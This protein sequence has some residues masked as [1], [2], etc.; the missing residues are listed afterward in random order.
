MKLEPGSS[1][2]PAATA[3]TTT[4]RELPLETRLAPIGSYSEKS[5]TVD[6]VW[7]AGGLVKRYDW[8]RGQY[9]M[10]KLSLDPAHVRMGR[11][12]SGAPLL[13][14][15]SRWSIHDVLGVVESASFANGE[16]RA[17]VRFS[18]REDVAPI[19]QDVK[20]GIVRNVSVGYAIYRMEQLPP[21]ATS[22]GLQI[23]RAID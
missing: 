8:E 23:Y 4:R 18:Q 3:P 14:S 21:D 1:G 6:L 5:R 15:H 19:L 20:D 2:G 11:M 17:T 7:S 12:E 22:D 10:E 13:N 9:Y 16:A